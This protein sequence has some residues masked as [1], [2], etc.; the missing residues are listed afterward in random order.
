MKSLNT[1][2][3]SILLITLPLAGFS[4]V[5]TSGMGSWGQMYNSTASWD[6]G[7]F[8]ANATFHPDYGWGIYLSPPN[9]KA[10]YIVGD[11]LFVIKLQDG[12]YKRLWIVEKSAASVYTFRYSD[13]DGSN[14]KEAV[15]DMAKYADKHF[16]Y[17]NMRADSVVDEQPP[18]ADWDLQLNKF[19]HREMEYMVTGF[20]SND[21]V[22]VSVFHDP[23]SAT[24]ADVTLADTTDFT[25][26]IAA[27]GNS[28]YELQGMSIVPLDT[29]V[30]FVKTSDGAIY[31]MQVIFFESGYS[32]LGRIG[33]RKKEFHGEPGWKYDTLVM[34]PSYA[35]EDYYNMDIGSVGSVSRGFWDIAFKSNW[36]GYTISIRANTTMGVELYTYPHADTSAWTPATSAGQEIMRVSG[37]KLY[38][39]PASKNIFILHQL[40]TQQP[41]NISVFDLTGKRVLNRMEAA[42]NNRELKL[43]VSKFPQGIYILKLQ[44]S[45]VQ[46]VSRF[47]IRR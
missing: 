39:V 45:D 47:S 30:Y 40:N 1:I 15:I 16:V 10:H 37:V 25:D 42:T 11:S 34:G 2:I 13:L 5:D 9:D 18:A 31:K 27:I 8:S 17:Y 12:S 38:P 35:A 14:E 32:G 46:A 26:S 21:G 29:M 6:E 4:Q 19:W 3:L 20:L 33:I 7:A 28:W 36:N 43:D 41:L 44:N 23:D 22:T 24:V